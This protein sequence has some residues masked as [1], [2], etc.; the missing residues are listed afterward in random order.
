MAGDTCLVF[1]LHTAL[2]TLGTAQTHRLLTLMNP[3]APILHGGRQVLSSSSLHVGV[4]WQMEFGVAL[5]PRTPHGW[6]PQYGSK[7]GRFPVPCLGIQEIIL[8]VS[9]EYS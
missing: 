5:T 1:H 8:L 6:K 3:V 2:C 9:P 4:F 7:T